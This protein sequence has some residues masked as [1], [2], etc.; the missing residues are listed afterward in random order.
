MIIIVSPLG[1]GLYEVKI[2]K[3]IK[4]MLLPLLAHQ[5]LTATV[6]AFNLTVILQLIDN[7]T[8]YQGQEKVIQER[9]HLISELCQKYESIDDLRPLLTKYFN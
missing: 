8:A 1:N 7:Y 5:T 3:T 2:V 6:L 4:N 9:K